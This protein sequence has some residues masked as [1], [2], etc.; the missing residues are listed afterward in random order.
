MEQAC[1]G[2][3][4]AGVQKGEAL[5]AHYASGDVFLF[6]SLTE[7]FGNVVPE[8]MAS[9]LAVVSFACAAA[10][11]LITTGQNGVL[12]AGGN[13]P[14]FVQAAVALATDR[15]MQE[16]VRSQAAGS[17]AHLNWNAIY[18]GFVA[19][20]SSVMERHGKPF[21]TATPLRGP[22]GFSQPSA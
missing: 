14:D 18:D 15:K 22:V 10:Q 13:E 4:Y 16:Q 19:T 5:A 8:A 6:P 3:I 1:P 9:G 20:L 17:V 12:V 11:E 7:T 21:A 2:A